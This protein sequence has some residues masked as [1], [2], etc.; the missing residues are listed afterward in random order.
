MNLL[1]NNEA[2]QFSGN[3]LSELVESLNLVNTNG[4]ALAINEK[5][6]PKNEWGGFQLNDNDKILII[7]ATQGG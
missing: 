5:V 3:N 1:V 6:V 4:I 2:R 7:K